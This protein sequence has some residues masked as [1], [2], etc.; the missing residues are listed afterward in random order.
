[1]ALY[2]VFLKKEPLIWG[3]SLSDIFKI[4]A[5][6]FLGAI[7]NLSHELILIIVVLVYGGLITIRKL[8]PKRHFEFLLSKKNL[9]P[10]HLSISNSKGKLQ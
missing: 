3:I 5:I 6:M 9:L 10:L 4:T 8:Y 7:L 1:M 2:P